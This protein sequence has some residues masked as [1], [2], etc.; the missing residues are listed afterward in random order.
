MT[1]GVGP[2]VCCLHC[3]SALAQAWRTEGGENGEE[4]RGQWKPEKKH[5]FPESGRSKVP[6]F[7]KPQFPH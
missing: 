4:G 3:G 2:L 7:H 6:T 1:E 5:G